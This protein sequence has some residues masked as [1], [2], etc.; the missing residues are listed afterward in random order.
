V[1]FRSDKV[2]SEIGAYDYCYT[3]VIPGDIHVDHS[4]LPNELKA[5]LKDF[6]SHKAVLRSGHEP[7]SAGGDTKGKRP[8]DEKPSVLDEIREGSASGKD[9]PAAEKTSTKSKSKPKKGPGL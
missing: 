5:I 8:R 7:I 1:L 9:A 4:R 3:A 2:L 6:R